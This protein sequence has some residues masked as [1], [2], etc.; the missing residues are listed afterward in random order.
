MIVPML[1]ALWMLGCQDVSDVWVEEPEAGSRPVSESWNVSFFVSESD[2]GAEDS[3]RRLHLEAAY[4]ASFEADSSYTVL[5]SDDAQP[6][7]H[8]RIFDKVTGL[9]SAMISADEIIYNDRD[10]R[11]VATGEVF[12]DAEGDRQLY[13]ERLIWHERSR[14]VFAPGFVRI[15]T[16]RERLEGYNL[17]A[18]ENLDNYRLARV[19]GQAQI[20]ED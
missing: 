12:V 10:R 11:F 13:S 2:L 9:E 15:V 1:L 6:K 20:E 18:D 16:P 19:T 8:A 7:V 5:R 3:R 4:M 17:D 14:A